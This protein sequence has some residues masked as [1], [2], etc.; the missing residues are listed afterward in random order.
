MLGNEYRIEVDRADR[1]QWSQM[2]ELFQDANIYQTWSYGA[3]RWKEKNLSHLVLR[4]GDDVVGMA[5]LRILRLAGIGLGMAY[6][7]WGPL[8]ERHHQ[9]SDLE[10]AKAMAC[11]LKAEYIDKRGLS[12]QV[13][14]NAFTG[15]PRANLLQSAFL[16]FNRDPGATSKYRTFVLDLAPP[17]EEL[18]R[19]LDAKWRNHLARSEKNNLKVVAGCGIEEFRRFCLLYIQM[20]ERK[21]FNSTVDTEQFA[22]IQD[23]LPAPLRMRVLICEHEGKPVAATVTSAIGDSA[24][25]LLGATND[26]GLKTQASYL[27][28]WTQIRWLKENGTRWYDLGGIDPER[29]PGVYSFKK[30]LSG[31]D[32]TEINP[33]VEYQ[34]PLSSA[35]IKAGLGLQRLTHT[36]QFNWRL[37]HLLTKPETQT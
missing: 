26:A 9:P 1:G 22:R 12:L 25:Y 36:S 13:L 6:L 11:A 10:S 8:V 27:L 14:P 19:R 3:V 35:I 21:R 23:D 5:Q 20:L 7:R 16:G 34:S 2:L 18:R 33:V 37:A 17:L 24:I 28:Q 31:A 30:G 15:T 29:N 32:V 4:R